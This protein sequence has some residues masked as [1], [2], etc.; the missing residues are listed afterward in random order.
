MYDGQPAPND[1]QPERSDGQAAS[2]EDALAR[3]EAG[4]DDALKTA[5]NVANALRRYHRAAQQGQMR[6]LRAASEAARRA[7]QAL[8]QEVANV[9]ESWEFDEEA[10]LQGEGYVGEL[11]AAGDREGLHIALQDNR[12]FS[13][14]AVVRVLP[15]E[16]AVQIDKSRERRIRPSFLARLLRDLQKRPPRFRAL[17]FLRGLNDAYHVAIRQDSQRLRPGSPVPLLDLYELLTLM[18]STAREYSR[19]EFTRDVYLLDQSGEDTT[20][21][22]ER[23]E[24]HASTG[25]KLRRGA[26]TIVAEDGREKRYYAVSFTPAARD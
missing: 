3:A 2:L 12:L 24:F 4:A 6:E 13:Y 10:Y 26:L 1:G 17:D 25:T 23:V 18:P 21:G 8:D 16:R 15:G 11:I 5:R 9:A 20:R 19:Q 7:V 14:P 22:G